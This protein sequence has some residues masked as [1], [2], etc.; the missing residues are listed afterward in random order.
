MIASYDFWLYQITWN[1]SV[2]PGLYMI[3]VSHHHDTFKGMRAEQETVRVE[4]VRAPCC[5]DQ[6]HKYLDIVSYVFKNKHLE[7]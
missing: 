7:V 3:S 2:T 5:S 1:Q 6:L 4:A